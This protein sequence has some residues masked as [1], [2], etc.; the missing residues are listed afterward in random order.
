MMPMSGVRATSAPLAGVRHEIL[1]RMQRAGIALTSENY[2][3]WQDYHTGRDTRLRRAMDILLTNGRV[4]DQRALH[5]LYVR[6]CAPEQ[7]AVAFRD[8]ARRALA[9]LQDVSGL[10]GD[11]RGVSDFYDA[12]Q[13]GEGATVAPGSAAALRPLVQRLDQNAE[14][15]E[16]LEQF[17]AEARQE[18]AT[19]PLTGLAN[20]RAFD[21]ALMHA[22]GG[23]MNSDTPLSLLLAD[24]DHFKQVNDRWGH[25]TG[26]AVL[27][28]VAHAISQAV[29]GRDTT[30]RYGGEEFAVILPD[31]AREG[32]IV[33]AENIRQAVRHAG[34]AV[35]GQTDPVSV[36][37][38]L[39]V[40]T[41]E[42]GEKLTNM[43]AHAD[44]A[45]YRAK[46]AGR[47]RIEVAP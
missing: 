3:V 7:E 41:Y 43:V 44:A 31:T 46:A 14:R 40:S 2:A 35:P 8:T 36:T 27:R 13:R 47:N 19:D 42:L 12:S 23:A 34:L 4:P 33:V 25:D 17:L 30:A 10:I 11:L 32:A 39:G 16:A 22:A 6:Y 29:R 28:M 20:R 37:I 9:T 18:A 5:Q 24:V 26:D 21:T 15:I 45:L 1:N 38:S